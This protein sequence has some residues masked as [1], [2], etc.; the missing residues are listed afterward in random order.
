MLSTPKS[1]QA[2]SRRK[3]CGGA[4]SGYGA[5]LLARSG[6]AKSVAAQVP[7]ASAANAIRPDVAAIDHDRILAA[8]EHY[9][10]LAPTPITSLRCDRSPGTLHDY[11][12]EPEPLPNSDAADTAKKNKSPAPFTAHR[13]A[14]FT[15]GLA[16]P[17]LAA[18]YLLTRE[19][20]YAEQAAVWLRTWFV[21]PATSMTPRLDYGQMI[22][23]STP[24]GPPTL[25]DKFKSRRSAIRTFRRHP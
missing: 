15:L 19:D 20:R 11:Y 3:F 22:V 2:I 18:A 24:T 8:A 7:P 17:A 10:T 6:L 12:S 13:D 23:T 4:A 21:D 9:L 14:V 1:T 25:G 5:L 16:V